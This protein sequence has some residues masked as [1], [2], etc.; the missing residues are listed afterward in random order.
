MSIRLLVA[1]HHVAAVAGVRSFLAGTEIEVAEEAADGGRAVELATNGAADLVLMA[2]GLPTEDGLSALARIKE[3]R[4]D[5]PVL[6]TGCENHPAHIAHAHKL[7]ASGF[8]PKDFSRDRLLGAIRRAAAGEHAWSRDE[9]RRVSGVATSSRS[10]ADL[11]APL[12]PRER[13]VLVLVAQGL[14]N[15][16]IAEKLGISFETVKEHVQHFI[17][18]IGVTDRTQAAVWAVRKGLL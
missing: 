5:L 13:D 10:E 9:I 2:I 11:E 8:L 3:A 14:T 18:K 12:T 15:R 1:D 6:I 16:A 4:A 17:R 7:G